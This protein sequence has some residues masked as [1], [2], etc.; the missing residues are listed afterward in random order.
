MCTVLCI[1]VSI[2]SENPRLWGQ[3]TVFLLQ[4]RW[5]R[6]DRMFISSMALENT[7]GLPG[8]LCTIS[9]SRLR[10]HELADIPLHLYGPQG[11]AEFIL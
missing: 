7:L 11:L 2:L 9:S 5:G 6:I 4:V 10:G 3:I 8:M 1:V